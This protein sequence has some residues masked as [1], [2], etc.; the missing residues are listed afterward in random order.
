MPLFEVANGEL[1][2]FRRLKGGADLYE[3]QIATHLR[4]P[5]RLF[6]GGDPEAAF[7]PTYQRPR[8]A[9][10]PTAIMMDS[11]SNFRIQ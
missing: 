8:R 4:I 1:V 9:S 3:K 2:P 10:E 6:L 5:M 11:S 7:A